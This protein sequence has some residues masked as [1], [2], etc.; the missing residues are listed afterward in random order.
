[1]KKSHR[2]G[3]E[4]LQTLNNAGYEAY[5]V[6]G[7]VRDY[8]LRRE[9]GDIDITTNARPDEVEALFDKVVATGKAFGTMTIVQE[10]LHFE[11]T[12]YRR[13]TTYDNHRHPDS[14]RF[15]K[16]LGEDLS[17]RDFT[18]NQLVMDKDG[19][20]HDHHGG[21]DDLDNKR[22]RTIGDPAERFYE[23]ALRMLRAFRFM[24][25][26]DFSM[27]EETRKALT[28]Q[29]HL[30]RKI[31]IERIQDELF[32]LFDA[33]NK[34]KALKAMVETDFASAL[35]G[36]EAGFRKLSIS[37]VIYGPLEAFSVLHIVDGL[38]LTL[39]RLPKKFVEAIKE[40][41]SLHMQTDREPF[42]PEALFHFGEKRCLQ[43]DTVNRIF[44]RK[45]QKKRIEHLEKTLPIRKVH[46]LP[47]RGAEI[48]KIVP[49]DKPHYIRLI[50]DTLL[51]RV[52]NREVENERGALKEEAWRIL[53]SLKESE[54]NGQL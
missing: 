21:R 54:N 18:V 53:Q 40:I 33:P 35:Y 13:E 30:I 6:G 52:L 28:E 16:T 39:W 37:P 43:A 4:I 34:Q 31:S 24:A 42:T 19:N 3:I 1:M 17:R 14:I 26:L 45:S 36:H 46:D 51:K 32:K 8:L 20:I 29:K 25:K 12:T 7:F 15:A 50:L 47:Y 5:F 10:G 44:G 48:S 41:E 49:K 9:T 38:D 2:L 11:V 27:E 22:L 23:D